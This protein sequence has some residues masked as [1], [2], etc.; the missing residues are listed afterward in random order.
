GASGG[1]AQ[2]PAMRVPTLLQDDRVHYNG[3]PI[4]IVVADTFEHA[5][6]AAMAAKVSY[7]EAAPALDI[8]KEPKIPA[9]QVKPLG[10]ERTY[11]RGDVETG[12]RSAAVKVE[13]TYTTPLENHNPMEVHNTI[14]WWEGDKLNVYDSTQGIFN[15]RNTLAQTFGIPRENVRVVSYF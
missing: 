11:K 5:T 1:G 13:H 15:V 9:D 14:A 10:G 8:S 6:A 7:V 2:R 12:L 3:Q 4:G